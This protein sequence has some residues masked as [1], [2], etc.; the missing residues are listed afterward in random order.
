MRI[1]LVAKSMATRRNDRVQRQGETTRLLLGQIYANA[2]LQRAAKQ[3]RRDGGDGGDSEPLSLIELIQASGAVFER[4]GIAPP[5]D[6]VYHRHLLSLSIDPDPD[7]RRKVASFQMRDQARTRRLSSDPTRYIEVA[8]ANLDSS[9]TPTPQRNHTRRELLQRQLDRLNAISRQR[10]L[11]DL[12]EESRGEMLTPQGANRK[13]SRT[14]SVGDSIR[15]ASPVSGRGGALAPSPPSEVHPIGRLHFNQ[16]SLSRTH[17]FSSPLKDQRSGNDE[18]SSISSEGRDQWQGELFMSSVSDARLLSAS[19]ERWRSVREGNRLIRKQKDQDVQIRRT[20]MPIAAIF[21]IFQWIQRTLPEKYQ[22]A[23]LPHDLYVPVAIARRINVTS[24][25]VTDLSLLNKFARRLLVARIKSILVVWHTHTMKITSLRSRSRVRDRGRALETAFTCMLQWRLF[26]ETR[27]CLIERANWVAFRRCRRTLRVALGYWQQALYQQY[28]ERRAVLGHFNSLK[29]KSWEQWLRAVMNSRNRRDTLSRFRKRRGVSRWRC[30]T[31]LHILTRDQR[32]AADGLFRSQLLNRSFRT[33]RQHVEYSQELDSKIDTFHAVRDQ[34]WQRRVMINWQQYVIRNVELFELGEKFVK[35]RR[36]RTLRLYLRNWSTWVDIQLSRAEKL[37][38]AAQ[39]RRKRTLTRVMY[40]W[41][42]HFQENERNDITKTRQI[43]RNSRVSVWQRWRRLVGVRLVIGALRRGYR[44]HMLGEYVDK[45]RSYAKKRITW[46]NTIL[47]VQASQWNQI[48]KR[49]WKALAAHRISNLERKKSAASLFL[50]RQ[51]IHKRNILHRWIKYT[52]LKRGYQ[53]KLSTVEQTIRYPHLLNRAW[54][55]WRKTFR[56]AHLGRLAAKNLGSYRISHTFRAWKRYVLLRR[57][58]KASCLKAVQAMTSSRVE[59]IFLRWKKLAVNRRKLKE[60]SEAF[61]LECVAARLAKYWSIWRIAYSRKKDQQLQ[62]LSVINKW[63]TQTVRKSFCLWKAKWVIQKRH[64]LLLQKCQ[65]VSLTR[66]L[67]M[68]FQAWKVL[69]RLRSNLSLAEKDALHHMERWK[70]QQTIVRWHQNVQYKTRKNRRIQLALVHWQH[71]GLVSPFQRWVKYTRSN[72]IY[73]TQLTSV[74][75]FSQQA[76]V[77]AHFMRWKLWLSCTKH[78]QRKLEMMIQHI[79]HTRMKKYVKILRHNAINRCRIRQ[80]CKQ[81]VFASMRGTLTRTF[82]AWSQY[83]TIQ[84]SMQSMHLAHTK[85]MQKWRLRR[86]VLQWEKHARMRKFLC[87]TMLRILSSSKVATLQ[88]YFK[89]WCQYIR[90]RTLRRELTQKALVYQVFCLLPAYFSRWKRFVSEQSRRQALILQASKFWRH[91]E[92]RRAFQSWA[93]VAEYNKQTRKAITRWQNRTVSQFFATWAGAVH[94]QKI[95]RTNVDRA[96]AVLEHR[97]AKTTF[98][99]WSRIIRIRRTLRLLTGRSS[100]R[101]MIS[102][103]TLWRQFAHLRKTIKLLVNRMQNQTLVRVFNSWKERVAFEMT[104]RNAICERFGTLWLADL[105]GECWKRWQCFYRT[106]R[107][108]KSLWLERIQNTLRFVFS[109][110]KKHAHHRKWRRECTGVVSNMTSLRTMSEFWNE[111]RIQLKLRACV[112]VMQGEM[113]QRR[114]LDTLMWRFRR[115]QRYTHVMRRVRLMKRRIE[116][117]LMGVMLHA[118]FI[119]YKVIKADERALTLKIQAVHRE[120]QRQYL[121]DQVQIRMDRIANSERMMQT[122]IWRR[123]QL[124]A[125]KAWL[126][127][128]NSK[129]ATRTL[130][131]QLR[132]KFASS[133]IEQTSILAAR[134]MNLRLAQAMMQWRCQAFKSRR[135]RQNGLLAIEHWHK[136]TCRR[137]FE[138]WRVAHITERQQRVVGELYV[139][140]ASKRTFLR[141]RLGVQCCQAKREL[142][143]RANEFRATTVSRSAVGAWKLF[144]ATKISR[145]KLITSNYRK[146]CVRVLRTVLG[147]WKTYTLHS[148][149]KSVRTT[150]SDAFYHTNILRKVIVEWKLRAQ[151]IR[152]LRQQMLINTERLQVLLMCS[153]FRAWRV[154]SQQHRKLMTIMSTLSLKS[155]EQTTTRAFTGWRAYAEI[156]IRHRCVASGFYSFRRYHQAVDALKMVVTR[157]THRKLAAMKARL[158]KNV[159]E[160]SQLSSLFA[161]WRKYAALNRKARAVTLQY[162]QGKLLPTYWKAWVIFVRQKKALSSTAIAIAKTWANISLKRAWN[163]I[164][165]YRLYR[166]EHHARLSLADQHSRGYQLQLAVRFWQTSTKWEQQLA[167]TRR[168]VITRWQMA[169]A[170]RC[171]LSWK[172]YTASRR[173]LKT[174]SLVVSQSSSQQHVLTAWCAW[175]KIFLVLRAGRRSHLTHYWRRWV[176]LSQEKRSLSCLQDRVK[177]IA[178]KCYSRRA[179]QAWQEHVARRKMGRAMAQMSS[180]FG[181]AMIVKRTFCNWRMFFE[182]QREKK[183]RMR[184]IIHFMQSQLLHSAFRSIVGFRELC[185]HR[186]LHYS[187]AEAFYSAHLK[188]KIFIEWKAVNANRKEQRGRLFHYVKML[189]SS[190]QFKS[191]R[192]WAEYTA[193][194]RVLRKKMVHALAL[195]TQLCRQTVFL[196]WKRM[197]TKSKKNNRAIVFQNNCCTRHALTH[198]RK[199]VILSKVERMIGAGDK[200]TIEASFVI[201]RKIVATTRSVRMLQHT[202]QKKRINEVLATCFLE[203]KQWSAVHTRCKRILSRLSSDNHLRFRFHLWKVFTTQRRRLS[204]LLLP[205]Q[206]ETA[207]A[208]NCMLSGSEGDV[209]TSVQIVRAQLAVKARSL[210]QFEYDWDL[211]S[212]WRYWRLAFHAVLFHRL[213]TLQRH[214]LAWRHHTHRQLRAKSVIAALTGCKREATARTIFIGWRDIVRQV[215]LLQ[216]ERQR[217]RQLWTIANTEMLRREKR[218]LRCHFA[219]WQSIVTDEQHL[220]SSADA[221]YRARFVTKLWLAWRHD[222]LEI[223]SKAHK[224]HNQHL[225]ELRRHGLSRALKTLLVNRDRRKRA[226]LVIEYCS[227]KRNDRLI[228]DILAQWHV[229]AQNRR[230]SNQHGE[231][232]ETERLRRILRCWSITTSSQRRHRAIIIIFQEHKAEQLMFKMWKQWEAYKCHRRHCCRL[233]KRAIAFRLHY[234]LHFRWYDQMLVARRTRHR[235]NMVAHQL[236]T[237]HQHRAIRKW[238]TF[239]SR[240]ILSRRCDQYMQR[241]FLLR[242][243]AGVK[244]SLATRFNEWTQRILA[245]RVLVQWHL[246]ARRLALWRK[247]TSKVLRARSISMRRIVW[248]QWLTL[249]EAAKR[250]RT[251]I[252]FDSQRIISNNFYGW[253]D[254]VEQ[255]RDE[256]KEKAQEAISHLAVGVRRR[257][258]IHWREIA[259]RNKQRRFVTLACVFKLDGYR[260]S[261]LLRDVLTTWRQYMTTQIKSRSL[262]AKREQRIRQQAMAGWRQWV[263]S[264]KTR[265][266]AKLEANR[267][268]LRRLVSASFFYWQNYALSWRE[269]DASA[270]IRSRPRCQIRRFTIESEYKSAHTEVKGGKENSSDDEDVR[271]GRPMSPVMKRMEKKRADRARRLGSKSDQQGTAQENIHEAGENRPVSELPT[272][273]EAVELSV[274]VHERLRVLGHK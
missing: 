265:Q 124:K 211:Q 134:W 107:L 213:R 35:W 62:V 188:T 27:K 153:C 273:A 258:F 110:W 34:H 174:T 163:A 81:M 155:D 125:F 100:E 148:R 78:K 244:L 47:A 119:S 60:S 192:S 216:W 135:V 263:R 270:S 118:G 138:S 207:N 199:F 208:F 71:I 77:R 51:V 221:Y 237:F 94:Y 111:W 261:Q 54:S 272:F 92:E 18:Q 79:Q 176:L 166:I 141:W 58:T 101:T 113:I 99:N 227:N 46:R 29:L 257:V 36:R 146:C 209:Q 233:K 154:W 271:G 145:R 196:V 88:Q 31:R 20:L 144:V 90:Q 8:S 103:F 210:Q 269:V 172:L 274:S 66:S 91:K 37:Y 202:I 215:R 136:T 3:E 86:C 220:Q 143:A 40:Q 39:N 231:Y 23:K 142:R 239:A 126:N 219:A 178:F 32:L 266:N 228:P 230:L 6:A 193:H 25:S 224:K 204:I 253:V 254:A 180:R 156:K 162:L 106:R 30:R 42:F 33:L 83:A 194:R 139:K 165:W 105:R 21:A 123:L 267:Y 12:E 195:R 205:M 186:R 171:L 251:A 67:S 248:H 112:R 121:I 84:H 38:E 260:Q 9:D 268:Y 52:V 191:F 243:H 104:R 5:E 11:S 161:R 182:Q 115:W 130:T 240:R 41:Q 16:N 212:V 181:D 28:R 152:A 242:W 147:E 15:P 160:S 10:K 22:L 168:A 158:F 206:D 98:S 149:V 85:A 108:V 75:K 132:Q 201:W 1:A 13:R 185:K 255:C 68:F 170:S 45:W 109:E 93:E 4:F 56:L 19:F 49:C 117:R 137:I 262:N 72:K 247:L 150:M 116:L 64:R 63:K 24:T 225:V 187:R 74:S 80:A 89:A 203:W 234:M 169:T 151:H 238:G 127:F 129:V 235:G 2:E 96:N 177:I 7:W 69:W 50:G 241:K 198:W 250:K 226:R 259:R 264:K 217:E 133:N 82:Y 246:V 53:T 120:Y 55:T 159:L 59:S 114:A 214:F 232:V 256:W 14:R 26:T 44:Q 57:Q 197:V 179:F 236:Q 189:Q 122:R 190:Q 222:Y 223:V 249:V 70:L 164:S 175:R 102:V 65:I 167:Y 61:T 48:L 87:S 17:R 76:S 97:R 140:Q 200:R 252:E 95:L 183:A 218:T 73:K 184:V 173:A 157:A 131:S 128:H 229:W 43:Q 245:K